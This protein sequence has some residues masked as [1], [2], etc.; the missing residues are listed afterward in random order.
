MRRA[1]CKDHTHLFF[2]PHTCWEDC[3]DDCQ[4]GRSEE[5]RFERVRQARELCDRCPVRGQC[6]D[7]AIETKQTQGIIGGMSER[8]R[9][10][11]AQRR[12]GNTQARAV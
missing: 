12:N 10:A 11:E 8:Q 7:W 2:S 9:K 1:E 5:G 6:L 3:P 4:A